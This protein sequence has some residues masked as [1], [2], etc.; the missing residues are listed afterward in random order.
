MTSTASDI[1]YGRRGGGWIDGPAVSPAPPNCEV[2]GRPAFGQAAP[3]TH[4]SCLEDDT[5]P[6]QEALW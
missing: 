1:R 2:C 5:T 6:A 4:R 3:A